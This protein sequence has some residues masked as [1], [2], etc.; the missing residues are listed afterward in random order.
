MFSVGRRR[1]P[2][3][4]NRCVRISYQAFHRRSP[5]SPRLGAADVIEPRAEGSFLWDVF[6]PTAAASSSALKV[7]F[8]LAASAAMEHASAPRSVSCLK[9]GVPT[10]RL[11]QHPRTRSSGLP[12]PQPAA[13]RPLPEATPAQQRPH[14]A[15]EAS[16][17]AGACRCLHRSRLIAPPRLT[18]QCATP[19]IR[20]SRRSTAPVPL[21]AFV[22]ELGVFVPLKSSSA[23]AWTRRWRSAR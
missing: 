4:S 20:S 11:T 5:P 3:C 8:S 23:A 6:V 9:P 21:A 13:V 15:D 7:S 16:L 2:T 18:R 17:G 22:I 14:E 12:I 10:R 19:C 1:R